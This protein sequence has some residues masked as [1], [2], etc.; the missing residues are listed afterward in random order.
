MIFIR[1]L[2]CSTYAILLLLP[3]LN[4]VSAADNHIND[5]TTLAAVDYRHIV[6]E[7][8]VPGAQVDESEIPAL[9]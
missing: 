6:S 1:Q 8:C 5:R 7:S 3:T 4:I 2:N 9:I